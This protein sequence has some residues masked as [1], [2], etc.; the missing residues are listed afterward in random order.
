MSSAAAGAALS[1]SA[2]ANWS[3][4]AAMVDSRSEMAELAVPASWRDACSSMCSLQ[5]CL[6]WRLQSAQVGVV[7]GG[8]AFTHSLHALLR[9]GTF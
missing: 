3:S 1:A 8:Q 4:F 5:W 9:K 2:W 7:V 6:K